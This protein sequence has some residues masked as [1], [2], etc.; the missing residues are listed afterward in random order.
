MLTL[1]GV[2]ATPIHTGAHTSSTHVCTLTSPCLLT[3]KFHTHVCVPSSTQAHSGAGAHIL[4]QAH[5][6]H[7]QVPS[8]SLL[9]L[10]AYTGDVR[11]QLGEP[12]EPPPWR[13]A[14]I[15]PPR[16]ART[17]GPVKEQR[18]DF[19][20]AGA[21]AT[22][23]TPQVLTSGAGPSLGSPRSHAAV[24]GAGDPGWKGDA[25]R[26]GGGPDGNGS[27]KSRK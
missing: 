10:A 4:S 21:A 27:G 1:V 7:T 17:D 23:W 24:K 2:S 11:W 15:P 9:S 3:S 12:T 16:E 26:S 19:Q 22:C 14:P 5:A 25:G 20:R 13:S 6:H 18:S 8:Q